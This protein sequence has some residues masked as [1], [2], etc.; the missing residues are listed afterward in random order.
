LAGD[1][2][3]SAS[4]KDAGAAAG[5]RRNHPLSSATSRR[6][7]CFSKGALLGGSLAP[8]IPCPIV[9]IE[10]AAAVNPDGGRQRRLGIPEIFDTHTDAL[11][12]TQQ[13]LPPWR[14]RSRAPLENPAATLERANP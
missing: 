10:A 4:L 12:A 8:A 9:V 13:S 6:A 14:M 3:E 2:E 1:G 11:F 7:T 5:P